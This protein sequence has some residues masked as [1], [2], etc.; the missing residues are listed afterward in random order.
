MSRFNRGAPTLS[1]CRP[2]QRFAALLRF[3]R[4]AKPN[5]GLLCCFYEFRYAPVAEEL[6]KAVDR[7]VDVRI[8]VDAKVNEY[9]DSKGNFHESLPAR[10]TCAPSR[11]H[12]CRV[13]RS[14]AERRGRERSSTTSS[15]C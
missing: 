9:T 1:V 3:I 10:R 15:W 13:R 7:G 8:I 5:D 14:S 2:F 4:S 11:R 6:K 12:N